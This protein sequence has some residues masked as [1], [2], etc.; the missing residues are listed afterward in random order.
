M[1]V[2]DLEYIVMNTFEDIKKRD[3]FQ[4]QEILQGKTICDISLSDPKA[5]KEALNTH[6]L[7]KEE[8]KCS[9]Q[10]I[11]QFITQGDHY[12]N[13]MFSQIGFSH[14]LMLLNYD[15]NFQGTI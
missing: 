12:R 2:P 13:S 7:L 15:F 8:D 6:L 9:K 4:T 11:L 5:V 14:R 3:F 10:S 1:R